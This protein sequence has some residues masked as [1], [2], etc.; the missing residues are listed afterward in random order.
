MEQ[1]RGTDILARIGGEEFALILPDTGLIGAKSIAEQFRAAIEDEQIPVEDQV[2]NVTASFGLATFNDT[3]ETA[4]S[5]F[6]RAGEALKRSKLGGRNRIS[7]SGAQTG[8]EQV[9]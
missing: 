4:S 7:L 2:L 1:L 3:T 6:A 8:T 9:A 5:L